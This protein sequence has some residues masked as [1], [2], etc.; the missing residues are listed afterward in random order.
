M[1]HLRNFIFAFTSKYLGWLAKRCYT[2][3]Q[4]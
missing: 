3:M 1:I 4:V 2:S